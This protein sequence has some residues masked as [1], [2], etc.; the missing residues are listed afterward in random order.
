M[1]AALLL[2]GGGFIVLS[3]GLLSRTGLRRRSAS[4]ASQLAKPAAV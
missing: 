1:G 2:T 4:R 3:T